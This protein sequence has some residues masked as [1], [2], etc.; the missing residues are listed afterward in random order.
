MIWQI[1]LFL[2]QLYDNVC[3][4]TEA[5]LKEKKSTIALHIGKIDVN[6]RTNAS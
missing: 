6:T 3:N 1:Y 2:T 5:E 4:F